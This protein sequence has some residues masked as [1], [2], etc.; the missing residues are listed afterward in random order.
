MSIK[1][2]PFAF[3]RGNIAFRLWGAMMVLAG[4]G[5]IFL[6]VVQ[7][8]LF[9]PNY[10]DASISAINANLEPL[11]EE[12]SGLPSDDVL[13]GPELLRNF[14][15]STNV[16]VYLVDENGNVLIS[17]IN[18]KTDTGLDTMETQKEIRYITKGLQT[19]LSGE[20]SKQ[21]IDSD[22]IGFSLVIG[23]PATYHGEC[24]A[25]FI[26]QSLAAM[27]TMQELNRNQLVML[28]IVMA[29]MASCIAVLLTRNFTKP[30]HNIENTV[31]RLAEGDLSAKPDVKR[32]DE[33][34]RLSKSVEELGVALQRVDV[35]R[36]E[37][38]ANVSHELSA[39]L[40]LI[41]G[42]SEKVRDVSGDDPQLRN[43]DMELIIRET[44]RL[45]RMVDDIMDYSKLQ[46]GYG[47]LNI[48]PSNL[49]ELVAAEV[50][51]IRQA[52]VEYGIKIELSGYAK[53]I[54][55]NVDSLKISQVMRNLLNNA[56]NHTADEQGIT[57]SIAKDAD[58][59]VVRVRSPGRPIPEEERDAIWE[60]YQRVQH[61]GGRREGTGI[62]LSIVATILEA[63]GFAYGVETGAHA[64]TFWFSIR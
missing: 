47:K 10:I 40:S 49:Y 55:V 34:G 19:V 29:L 54:E 16:R 46:S 27:Q 39:P 52:A 58:S 37:V 14:S 8:A 53:E 48:V 35:L 41:L 32:N 63:H 36:K 25:I 6:W 42:Y 56:V 60:R 1:N 7:I 45:S 62:G 50:E 13:S 61:Q 17:Y 43:Q 12:L 22:K 31:M 28:S 33:L 24:T 2:K 57:V 4:I 5:V 3:L 18:G 15:K 20:S 9:E 11:A 26:H 51:A 30:I 21:V 64:N 44:F 59:V 23:A 38:I